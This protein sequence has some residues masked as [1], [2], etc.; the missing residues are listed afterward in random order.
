[1]HGGAQG[2]GAPIGN[3]NAIKHGFYT[4]E[5]IAERKKTKELIQQMKNSLTQFG[6][7]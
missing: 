4:Q 3:C 5:A 1:M 7:R 6:G 2:S